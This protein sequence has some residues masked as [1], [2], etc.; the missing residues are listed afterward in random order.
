MEKVRVT[1]GLPFNNLTFRSRVSPSGTEGL[2]VSARL[3]GM[4]SLLSGKVVARFDDPLSLL[5]PKSSF[6]AEG[7]AVFP[8][9]VSL[10][11][12]IYRLFLVLRDD[13]T[14][15][16]SISDRRLEVPR[17]SGNTL[18]TSSLVLA[19]LID[20]LPPQTQGAMF[21]VGTFRVRPNV[22]GKYRRSQPLNIFQEAY[23]DAPGPLTMS[24]LITTEGKEFKRSS[25]ELIKSSNFTFVKTLPL[26]DF[27]PGRYE[28]QTTVTD[29]ANG[30]SA[31][32][33]A[34]FVVE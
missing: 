20:V 12:G 26:S 30:L 24:V 7:V 15:D 32:S 2:E 25:E 11:P 33:R 19:E 16:S 27:I 8:Q 5:V 18:S 6:R 9:D 14:G 3:E 10:P 31:V 34:H 29:P 4:V 17:L 1:I 22:T 13:A 28:I 21:Q 23:S